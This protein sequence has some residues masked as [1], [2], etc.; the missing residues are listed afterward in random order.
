[1]SVI[2][3]EAHYSLSPDT[4]W[5]ELRHIERHVHW[6]HDAVRIEF[7]SPRREGV[8][9]EF[10][11]DTKV[12]PF[13]TRDVMTISEWSPPSVMGVTHHGLITGAG[14]FTLRTEDS[15]TLITWREELTFPWWLAGHLGALAAAPVLRAIWRRN[16]GLLARRLG[17]D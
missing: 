8:G 7:T 4:V 14:R 3:V 9:T 11:C 15:G 12:G 16:L 13:R 6:M 1:M 2:E 5:E 17:S 10:T